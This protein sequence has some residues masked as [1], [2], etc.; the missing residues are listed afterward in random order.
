MEPEFW[1]SILDAI[2]FCD[3]ALPE[4]VAENVGMACLAASRMSRVATGCALARNAFAATVAR[5]WVTGV[6]ASIEGVIEDAVA[7]DDDLYISGCLLAPG[8]SPELIASIKDMLN[9]RDNAHPSIDHYHCRAALRLY[10]DVPGGVT[11]S[12][13]IATLDGLRGQGTIGGAWEVDSSF[14][15]FFLSLLA[16]HARDRGALPDLLANWDILVKQLSSPALSSVVAI[17]LSV[18]PAKMFPDVL[19][20]LML[21][22]KGQGG[23]S[24]WL[25]IA[26]AERTRLIA[27]HHFLDLL[28]QE[29]AARREAVLMTSPSRNRGR[30]S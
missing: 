24:E 27:D 13:A 17:W 4:E 12:A 3:F 26:P 18:V 20:H 11:G 16:R 2:S 6:E 23:I 25:A 7:S 1:A 29:D 9:V 15:S 10:D 19:T 30:R 21:S 14:H 22:Q 8:I 28:C 5:R